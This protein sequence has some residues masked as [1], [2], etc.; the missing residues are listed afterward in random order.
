MII[1][2]WSLWS[3]TWSY[4]VQGRRTGWKCT[5]WTFLFASLAGAGE[6][7][8]KHQKFVQIHESPLFSLGIIIIILIHIRHNHDYHKRREQKSRC[9]VVKLPGCWCENG[10]WGE[11]HRRNFLKKNWH[12]RKPNVKKHRVN[13]IMIIIINMILIVSAVGIFLWFRSRSKFAKSI[14]CQKFTRS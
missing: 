7:A 9:L 2:W 14:E 10:G 8:P 12:Q 5:I 4:L 13:M 11:K 1:I 6:S 3:S